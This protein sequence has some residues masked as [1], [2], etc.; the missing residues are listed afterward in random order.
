MRRA[1]EQLLALKSAAFT[2]EHLEGSTE[3]FPGLEMTKA[4]GVVDIPGKFE[5]TVDAQIAFPKSF[6]EVSIITIDDTAYIT[7]FLNGEWREVSPDSLPFSV[8]GLGATLAG[9][10]DVVGAPEVVAADELR[11]HETYRIRGQIKS[12]DLA[13]LVPGA[14][15]GFDVRLELW[16]GR[17]DG[18]LHQV[19]IFGKVVPTDDEEAVR[20]LTLDDI[21]LPVE[22]NAP[23]L[24]G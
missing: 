2:L 17:A 10:V 24:T 18:L 15:T 14:G 19:L 16:L 7:D 5:V 11:G 4:S 1:V 13:A 21:N 22:I 6:L 3:L 12:E 20:Q 8:S 23:S 9:I